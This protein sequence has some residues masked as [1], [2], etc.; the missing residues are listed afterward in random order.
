M[1]SEQLAQ[2]PTGAYSSLD[3]V[4]G[5]MDPLTSRCRVDAIPIEFRCKLNGVNQYANDTP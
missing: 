2:R 4:Q 5:K 3:Q 1:P